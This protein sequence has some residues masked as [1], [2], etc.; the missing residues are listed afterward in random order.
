M[1]MPGLGS[2]EIDDKLIFCRLLHRQLGGLLAFE[3]AIDVDG[4]TPIRF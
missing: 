2:L 1:V 4:C 3:D